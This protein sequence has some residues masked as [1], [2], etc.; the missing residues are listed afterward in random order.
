[1]LAGC[2]KR[3]PESAPSQANELLLYCGAGIRPPADELV[4]TFRQ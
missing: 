4:E 1:M 2:G 3:S